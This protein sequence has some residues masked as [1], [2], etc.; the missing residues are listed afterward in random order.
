M[1]RM[2]NPPHP[3]GIVADSLEYLRVSA[4]T[5]AANLGVPTRAV[6]RILNEK[7]P[8]TAEIA[9]RISTALPGPSPRVW[10]AMQAAYDV[11]QAEHRIDTSSIKRYKAPNKKNS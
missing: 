4:K 10:L 3:G 6:S 5:F 1:T 9:L 7:D 2:F 8:I 11:W